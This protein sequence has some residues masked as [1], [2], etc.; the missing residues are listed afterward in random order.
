MNNWVIMQ[1]LAGEVDYKPTFF[2]IKNQA[3]S[4]SYH[5]IIRLI[6]T[7]QRMMEILHWNSWKI[8]YKIELVYTFIWV[9]QQMIS[10][11][12]TLTSEYLDTLFSSTSVY[13]NNTMAF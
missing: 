6:A 5:S 3:N 2:Q 12:R 13:G 7:F 1:D 9:M 10:W 8:N 4:N 11:S